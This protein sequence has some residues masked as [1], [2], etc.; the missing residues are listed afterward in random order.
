MTDDEKNFLALPRD[1]QLW[2][3]Y[4]NGGVVTDTDALPTL[5]VG[6]RAGLRVDE[7]GKLLVAGNFSVDIGDVSAVPTGSAGTPAPEVVTIQGITSMTPLVVAAHAVTNAG[8]FAVQATQSGTWNVV[9]T[10][11]GT[12]AVQA[13]CTNAGT[14]AV[15]AAQSGTWN[16]VCT[17]AGTFAVQATLTAETTKVIGTV[18]VATAQRAIAGDTQTA[19]VTV[20]AGHKSIGLVLSSDFVGTVAGQVVTGADDSTFSFVAPLGDTLGSL[21]IT[22]SAGTVRIWTVG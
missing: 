17:N 5:N 22:R 9:C 10:N 13:A 12:F 16:V 6:D 20:A 15:Q 8:T 3:I 14:F 4:T 21:A 11:S 18:N 7:N 2:K 19:D 1:R